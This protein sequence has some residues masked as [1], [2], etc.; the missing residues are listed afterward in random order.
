M[1]LH[2]FAG[3]VAGSSAFS[4]MGSLVEATRALRLEQPDLETAIEAKVT[5]REKALLA[6]VGRQKGCLA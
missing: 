5:A 1:F 4:T 3:A 6:Q 2:P